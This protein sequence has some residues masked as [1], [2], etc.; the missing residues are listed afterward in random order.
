MG[1]DDRLEQIGILDDELFAW[2]KP[3]NDM[4]I[5][6]VLNKWKKYSDDLETLL[7]EVGDC[8]FWIVLN[9]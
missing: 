4:G 7:Y 3:L 2:V 1:Q 8:W 6:L 9:H 5:F